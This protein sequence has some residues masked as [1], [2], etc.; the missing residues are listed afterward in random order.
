MIGKRYKRI[1]IMIMIMVII[2]DDN[3]KISNSPY[4]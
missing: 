4:S 1:M 2:Y 3:N